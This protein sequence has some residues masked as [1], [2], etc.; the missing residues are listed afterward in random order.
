MADYFTATFLFMNLVMLKVIGK[1]SKPPCCKDSLSPLTCQRLQRTNELLFARR[2]NSDAEFRL[3]QCCTTCNKFDGTLAY[4][5]IA[6]S[7][8]GANCFD[9]YGEKFC[10]RYVNSTDVWTMKH[11]SCDG[12]SPH[13]AF[14]S[15]RK[16]CGFC[17]FKTV[18]YSLKNA[19]DACKYKKDGW[20]ERL[21]RRLA[22]E[23]LNRIQP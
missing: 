22:I 10:G 21:R 11:W 2:C 9:R 19:I 23:K 16:S 7:L 1:T 18:N 5:A 17:D 3:I 20:R 13:I 15:C 12:D 6:E 8:V 14:R 4:D